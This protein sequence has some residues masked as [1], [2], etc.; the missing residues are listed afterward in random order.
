MESLKKV[1]VVMV[2]ILVLLLGASTV[3]MASMGGMNHGQMAEKSQ[4]SSSKPTESVANGDGQQAAGQMRDSKGQESTAKENQAGTAPSNQIILP[5]PV[6]P[7]KTDPNLYIMELQNRLKAIDQANGSIAE[8]SGGQM[9]NGQPNG[10]SQPGQSN[11]NELHRQFYELGQNVAGMEQS[12]DSLKQAIQ[13]NQYQTQQPPYYSYYAQNLPQGINQYY[14]SSQSD[15]SNMGNMSGMAGM[16][17]MNSSQMS[18]GLSI[19]NLFDSDVAK[20][21]FSL[22]LLLSVVLGIVAIVGFVGSLFKGDI[23]A[24]VNGEPMAVNS[25]RVL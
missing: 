17:G 20:T 7:P 13:D 21:V 23:P 4:T 15:Q 3:Y 25:E 5:V 14:P 16:N 9:M 18:H 12:L 22:V 24:V 1:L 8:N 6:T 2:V 10:S 11:M 19:S